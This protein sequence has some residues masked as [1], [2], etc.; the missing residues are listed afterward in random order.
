MEFVYDYDKKKIKKIKNVVMLFMEKKI[1][2]KNFLEI[3]SIIVIY[4]F[5]KIL[6][7]FLVVSIFYIMYM[8]FLF[9]D[10]WNM[11]EIYECVEVIR[12]EVFILCCL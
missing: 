12:K 8:V 3:I 1:R 2:K 6:Y 9:F 7:L 4:F 11:N 10:I 5:I